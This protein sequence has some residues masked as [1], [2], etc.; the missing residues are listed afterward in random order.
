MFKNL[1]KTQKNIFIAMIVA[2]I[3]LTLSTCFFAFVAFDRTIRV[4]ELVGFL[5]LVIHGLV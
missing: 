3:I 4:N 2:I 5:P 1:T